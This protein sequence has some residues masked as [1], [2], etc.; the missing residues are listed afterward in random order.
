MGKRDDEYM[1]SDQI[2]LGFIINSTG[3]CSPPFRNIITIQ[4]KILNKNLQILKRFI[5]CC[6]FVVETMNGCVF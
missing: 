6:N 3:S 1:F 2:E 5:Q 4:A